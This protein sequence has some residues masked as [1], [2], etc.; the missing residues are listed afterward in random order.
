MLHPHIIKTQHLLILCLVV[1]IP[2]VFSSC[3]TQNNNKLHTI[4]VDL[5]NSVSTDISHIFSSIEYVPLVSQQRYFQIFED[6]MVVK[7]FNG[8][9]YIYQDGDTYGNIFRFTL[10]GENVNIY[11]IESDGPNKI[12]NGSDFFVFEDKLQVIDSYA[13]EMVV[14]NLDT[15]ELE[16]RVPLEVGLNKG[17]CF[18]KTCYFFAR[19]VINGSQ[20]KSYNIF[21]TNRQ[22]DIND[23]FLPIPKYLENYRAKE[24]NFSNFLNGRFLFKNILTDTIYEVNQEEFVPKY[25]ID[26]GDVWMSDIVYEALFHDNGRMNRRNFL[27][28]RTDHVFDFVNVF[29]TEN[30]IILTTF[31][32][33]KLHW[34]F[35]HLRNKK[36]VSFNDFNNDKDGSI[37]G[38]KLYWPRVLDQNRIMFIL[39]IEEIIHDIDYGM[40]RALH[41]EAYRN[42]KSYEDKCDGVLVVCKLNPIIIS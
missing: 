35:H 14:F 2:Y 21:K 39:P 37:L 34:I 36:T 20:G 28:N 24:Y 17:V 13:S 19:N 3:N 32:Q 16:S 10:E 1:T 42:L 11:P 25:K 7:M 31:Y 40:N 26:L 9:I 29:Q 30:L 4:T 23:K 22:F 15:K 5:D 12:L 8:E 6:W 38:N 41:S 27:Y 18:S 33:G